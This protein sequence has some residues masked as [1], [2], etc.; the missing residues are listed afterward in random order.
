MAELV[1]LVEVGRRRAESPPR[2]PR[3]AMAHRPVR[4]MSS[5]P[6]R[7]ASAP[8]AGPARTSAARHRAPV[9][10]KVRVD[11][12]VRRHR[13]LES[14]ARAVRVDE[15]HDV[16][17]RRPVH[18]AQERAPGRRDGPAGTR[19]GGPVSRQPS[20]SGSADT[21]GVVRALAAT[22][23]RAAD[24]IDVARR[25]A[26]QP[27]PV[28]GPGSP[29]RQSAA[30]RARPWPTGGPARRPSLLLEHEAQLDQ[31]EAGT[32]VVPRAAP[33]P[34][35]LAWASSVHRRSSK[36]SAVSSISATPFGCRDAGEHARAASATACCVS[37][38]VKSIRPPRSG[39]AGGTREA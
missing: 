28:A 4:A 35:R 9:E 24:S 29:T 14:R 32:A 27:R 17:R 8:S 33:G 36:R 6:A 30:R 10:M 2:R 15:R 31:A 12:A 21:V 19:E 25:H 1:A 38:K 26:G 11:L 5:M 22:S 20:P 3:A 39:T 13:P 18:G 34:S 23:L 7:T 16:P 37:S